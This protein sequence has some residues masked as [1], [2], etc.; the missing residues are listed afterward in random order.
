MRQEGVPAF[1]RDRL[2]RNPDL[3]PRVASGG[4]MAAVAIV[5]IVLGGPLLVLLAALAGMAMAW[6]FRRIH[7]RP[8]PAPR[9][10]DALYVA[11]P[12]GAAVLATVA[13][14]SQVVLMVVSAAVLHGVAD[15]WGGRTWRWSV[16]GLVLI[17]LACAAFPALRAAEPFGLMTVVWLVAVVVATDVGAYGVGRAL[18]GPKLW[19]RVS[20]NK[21]WA[22]AVGGLV[23]AVIAGALVALATPEADVLR[24]CVVSAVT[25]AVA[26]AGD[27][28]ESTVKRHFGVKDAGTLIP[29]HGGALDRLDGFTAATLAVAA[30]TYLNGK[31]VFLS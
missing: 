9:F 10:Q 15:R 2:A 14:P 29:G 28:C 24:V 18:R 3:G 26:Q 30:T 11:V 5:P 20:P 21:T 19:P 7:T 6:E 4:V 25:A 1:L 17:A 31:P 13:P 23:C 27:L 22:G 12:A 16:P 8:A